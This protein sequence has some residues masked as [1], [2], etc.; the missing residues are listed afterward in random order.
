MTERLT[1]FALISVIATSSYV[2]AQGSG[3]L[4]VSLREHAK[5]IGCAA[6][7]GYYDSPGRVDPPY[8]FG[9]RYRD[10]EFSAVYWCEP[11]VSGDSSRYVESRLVIWYAEHLNQAA[12]CQ[13]LDWVNPAAGLSILH[14]QRLSLSSF[15][16]FDEEKTWGPPGPEG[17]F[18]EGPI[19]RSYYDGIQELFYCHEGN[20]LVW[21]SD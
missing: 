20:W 15:F 16:I 12:P 9:Y 8:V 17:K 4:P 6:V 7:K 14:G 19:I 3:N 5:S 18:T 13:P 2:R 21:Q 1:Y 10:D 11:F